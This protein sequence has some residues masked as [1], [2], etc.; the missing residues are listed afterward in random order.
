MMMMMMMM[1]TVISSSLQECKRE[2][3]VFMMTRGKRKE[4]E[5]EREIKSKMSNL[6]CFADACEFYLIVCVQV[7]EKGIGH[8][9]N[10]PHQSGSI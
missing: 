2:I 8:G 3:C 4:E 5:E 1:M 9:M 6:G 10:K 7:Y